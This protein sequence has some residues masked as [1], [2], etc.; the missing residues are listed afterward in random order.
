MTNERPGASREHLAAILAEGRKPS[1]IYE[2]GDPGDEI[3]PILKNLRDRPIWI[4]HERNE[5]HDELMRQGLVDFVID[6][7]PLRQARWG[8]ETCSLVSVLSSRH[9]Q[10]SEGPKCIF[11]ARQTFRRFRTSLLPIC[12]VWHEGFG[13]R[14]L[15]R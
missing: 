5:V 9:S 10:T 8:S 12:Q 6:Q 7:D 13:N 1:A 15:R 4:G 11:F 3:A 14:A 2:T